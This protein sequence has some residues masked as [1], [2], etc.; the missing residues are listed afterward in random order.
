VLEI[1]AGFLTVKISGTRNWGTNCRKRAAAA[2][3]LCKLLSAHPST[4]LR[5]PAPPARSRSTL[6]LLTQTVLK[7]RKTLRKAIGDCRSSWANSSMAVDKAVPF[8]STGHCHPV[9]RGEFG[10]PCVGW[11]TIWRAFKMRKAYFLV[12]GRATKGSECCSGAL[13][14]M[15]VGEGQML[16]MTWLRSSILECSVIYHSQTS[17]RLRYAGMFSAFPFSIPLRLCTPP[18]RISRPSRR[19]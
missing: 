13:K 2:Q 14:I 19:A 4:P 18:T 8:Q 12:C 11:G 16:K 15:Q 10:C 6:R 3:L 5:S 17:G 7:E 9:S 1:V